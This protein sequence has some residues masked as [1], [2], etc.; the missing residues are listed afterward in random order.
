MVFLHATMENIQYSFTCVLLSPPPSK[1][2]LFC[3]FLQHISYLLEYTSCE[4]TV[5]I[6]QYFHNFGHQPLLIPPLPPFKTQVSVIILLMS[7]H[8][9]SSFLCAGIVDDNLAQSREY[10]ASTRSSTA[11][12]DNQK[13]NIDGLFH[14]LCS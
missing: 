14:F 9:M 11:Q 4:V 8:T 2:V 7:T 12:R 3:I 1:Y 6:V 10:V 13:L 5:E